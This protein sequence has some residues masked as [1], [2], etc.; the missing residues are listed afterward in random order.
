LRALFRTWLDLLLETECLSDADRRLL[1]SPEAVAI[2]G[3][4]E[5]TEMTGPHKMILLGA[6]GQARRTSI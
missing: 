1:A 6:M 5:S 3:D 2:L 4:V